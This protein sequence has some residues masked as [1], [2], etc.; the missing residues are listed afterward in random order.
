[1]AGASAT[2]N[3]AACANLLL[4]PTTNVSNVYLGFNVE[5][6]YPQF[7][8]R[9]TLV[10]VLE[11]VS[12]TSSFAT[13]VTVQSLLVINLNVFVKRS[14]YLDSIASFWNV[15]LASKIMLPLLAP[16]SYTHLD[17]YKRQV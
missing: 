7:T 9:E 3:A 2:A 13:I 4:F 1:M 17:V 15:E 6:E 14:W 5:F 11:A 16:V 8:S 12:W 10:L